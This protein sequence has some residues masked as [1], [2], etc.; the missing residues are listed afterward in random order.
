MLVPYVLVSVRRLTR[1]SYVG[2]RMAELS[3]IA[4]LF[5]L[6]VRPNMGSASGL[7]TWSAIVAKHFGS[8]QIMIKPCRR[9]CFYVKGQTT[10]I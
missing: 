5:E 6:L 1:I 7:K 9:N 10:R 8:D 4:S 2:F 3:R